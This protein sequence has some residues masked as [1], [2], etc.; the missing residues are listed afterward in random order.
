LPVPCSCEAAEWSG[1]ADPP[2]S[3]VIAVAPNLGWRNV[4]LAALL[5]E[6]LGQ[7][8]RVR[9]DLAAAAWAS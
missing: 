8:V 4:P 7:Q 1:R 6:R 2:D 5:A 3:G 9:D